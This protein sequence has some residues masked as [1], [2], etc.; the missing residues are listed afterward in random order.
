MITCLGSCHS[1]QQNHGETSR[2]QQAASCGSPLVAE[3]YNPG[4]QGQMVEGIRV[5]VGSSRGHGLS[6]GWTLTHL[7]AK[8]GE[9]ARLSSGCK[10]GEKKSSSG[11]G[12]SQACPHVSLGLEFAPPCDP[13]RTK[14]E[15]CACLCF[16][17]STDGRDGDPRHWSEM[18]EG[19]R[20]C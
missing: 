6:E 20:G 8:V 7:P 12:R 17:Q 4:V 3:L 10:E 14:W 19:G 11:N 18:R 16:L 5:P 15:N 1:F 9:E 2:G 13:E